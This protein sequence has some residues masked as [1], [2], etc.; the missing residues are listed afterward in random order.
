M[1]TQRKTGLSPRLPVGLGALLLLAACSTPADHAC[2]QPLD[3]ERKALA[4][5]EQRAVTNQ[6]FAPGGCARDPAAAARAAVEQ[7]WP[8]F[9][10]AHYACYD[11]EDT[12]PMRHADERTALETALA[13]QKQARDFGQCLPE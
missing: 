1:T 7:C 13:Q 6:I 10:A 9:A 4:A 12:A 3:A 11:A 2:H 5:C 8:T